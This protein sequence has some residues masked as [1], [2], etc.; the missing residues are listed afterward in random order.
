SP[1]LPFVK[2]LDRD[3]ESFDL[4]VFATNILGVCFDEDADAGQRLAGF[5]QFVLHQADRFGLAIDV[6]GNTFFAAAINNSIFLD[7]IPV[8]SERSVAAAEM[9]ARLA[10][11]AD[12]VVP[13]EVV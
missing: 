8:W 9:D 6:D 11:S 2:V 13:D 4:V 3:G 7:S 10:A 12:V 1:H 5:A